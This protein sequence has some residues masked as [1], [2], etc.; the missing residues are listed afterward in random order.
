MDT[1]TELSAPRRTASPRETTNLSMDA[2]K[3][4]R[5]R[6]DAKLALAAEREENK[7]EL[8]MFEA[9]AAA[10]LAQT[11]A[12]T[13]RWQI[14]AAVILVLGSVSAAGYFGIPVALEGL[15]MKVDVDAAEVA[16]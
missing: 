16:P 11:K 6:E 10:R 5:A 2:I 15:G 13:R 1:P 8:E 3:D 7:H 14:V 12:N 4:E 9:R